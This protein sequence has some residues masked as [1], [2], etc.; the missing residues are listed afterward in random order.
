MKGGIH[1]NKLFDSDIAKNHRHLTNTLLL[2]I[3][4]TINQPYKSFCC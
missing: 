1:E 2:A 4:R 3:L